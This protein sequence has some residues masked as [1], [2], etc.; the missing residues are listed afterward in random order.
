MSASGKIISD[1]V[2]SVKE[3]YTDTGKGLRLRAYG[4]F[5]YSLQAA[6]SAPM[7]AL[8]LRPHTGVIPWQK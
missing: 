4:K 1:K 6:L 8:Q 2:A 3:L 7:E 5:S